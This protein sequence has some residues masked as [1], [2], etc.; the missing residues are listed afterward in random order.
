MASHVVFFDQEA[1]LLLYPQEISRLPD[2]VE[3][4]CPNGR[5]RLQFRGDMLR[6]RATRNS[7]F[8]LDSSW[9]VQASEPATHDVDVQQ[10]PDR[11]EVR[12]RGTIVELKR[13]PLRLNVYDAGGKCIVQDARIGF[14]G[15]RPTF[16]AV[17]Q[18]E[19]QI[20]GTGMRSTPLNRRG[21]SHLLWTNNNP[22]PR[23]TRDS[24]YVCVPFTLVRRPGFAWGVYHDNTA[25]A[26]LD[27]GERAPNTLAYQAYCGE[28]DA[29]VIPG[30]T[31][32]DVLR[33]YT[34]LTGRI[35]LP[36]KWV[37]LWGHSRYGMKRADHVKHIVRRYREFGIPLSVLF[38]D[39]DYMV[40]NR[41]WTWDK[42]R[43][44]EIE[45][46]LQWLHQ[47]NINVVLI[48]DP[49][50]P[51]IP[52]YAPFEGMNAGNYFCRRPDGQLAV[53][54]G[55]AG[56]SGI[57]D[58]LN[59]EC[60]N[61]LAEL[62]A[63][64]TRK[65]GVYWWQDKQ[66]VALR[67][68]P[69]ASS[70]GDASIQAQRDLMGDT[71]TLPGDAVVH[72][73]GISEYEVHNVFPL[74]F[75]QAAHT[76]FRRADS[77]RRPFIL[78]R[79]GWAGAQRILWGWTGDNNSDWGSLADSIPKLLNLGLSGL[80]GYGTDVGGFFSN[81]S[82]DLLMRWVQFSV[83]TP[84][85]RIHSF[86]DCVQQTPWSFGDT[87]LE[88]VKKY[89]EF[90]ARLIP[91]LEDLLWQAMKDGTPIMR[92]MFWDNPD[93]ILP[94]DPWVNYQYR[95]GP[96]VVA[97]VIDQGHQW[98]MV[99]LPGTG[100]V[101]YDYWSHRPYAG[102]MSHHVAAPIDVLPLFIPAGG[103]FPMGDPRHDTDT[104][105]QDI[106]VSVF[107]GDK[108]AY[109]M[110]L[111][112]GGTRAYKRGVFSTVAIS[113]EGTAAAGKLVIGAREGAYV[114]PARD[115]TARILV[116]KEPKRVTLDGQPVWFDY[117]PHKDGVLEVTFTDDG[118][119][120][121]LEYSSEG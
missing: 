63:S 107:T 7:Q 65:F 45:E 94:P 69:A 98:K 61:F 27:C 97:P 46:L 118:L 84:L 41:P 113:Y 42:E 43:F 6:I 22:N 33:R 9:V 21:L 34:E 78:G 115:V 23:F 58:L 15:E 112:D 32:A 44:G 55:F 111:E 121:T 100:R 36:P 86:Y 104:P 67:R 120:H 92:P 38:I 66:E 13:D 18:Q 48:V 68:D 56:P 117:R 93:E 52:G 110:H 102:G 51:I 2:G 60:F 96:F 26:E 17:L 50:I 85:S 53:V 82:P 25:M 30:P 119:C 29:Y 73:G 79:A 72:Y 39:L 116:V 109:L 28:I 35:E 31:P 12:C 103:I 49:L 11:I 40:D 37:T 74:L 81:C 20:Y 89:I 47:R 3:C 101:W 83:F 91:L 64:W 54:Q 106:A 105:S 24:M 70:S 80:A 19:D 16:T 62:F 95:W 10:N 75:A 71:D 5:L 88:V 99:Y 76:G 8:R 90:R 87:C 77:D 14:S 108:G 1:T 57:P 59:P 114:P 4:V